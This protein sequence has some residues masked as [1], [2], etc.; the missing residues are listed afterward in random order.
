M[1]FLDKI[2]HSEPE[3]VQEVGTIN[4]LGIRRVNAMAVP[5]R[6]VSS[7]EVEEF[8][9]AALTAPMFPI[10]FW[11]CDGDE[12]KLEPL[13]T[14]DYAMLAEAGIAPEQWEILV[15]EDQLEGKRK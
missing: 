6:A 5:A 8:E 10:P 11:D 12:P 1:D 4:K 13:M 14:G 7:E 15:I 2:T 9:H 3:G